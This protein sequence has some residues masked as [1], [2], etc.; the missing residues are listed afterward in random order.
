MSQHEARKLIDLVI[1]TLV[2]WGIISQEKYGNITE[3]EQ[4]KLASI[5]RERGDE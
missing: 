3:K 5:I 2:D 4:E 1:E